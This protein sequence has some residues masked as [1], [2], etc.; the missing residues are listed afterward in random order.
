MNT[1]YIKDNREDLWPKVKILRV[2]EVPKNLPDKEPYQA[3]IILNCG[4]WCYSTFGNEFEEKQPE[5]LMGCRSC[6]MRINN[7]TNR[8]TS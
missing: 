5:T 3:V 7:A 1:G 8:R 4:H 2:I 6:Y